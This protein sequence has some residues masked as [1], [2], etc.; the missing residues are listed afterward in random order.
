MKIEFVLI[1]T[2]DQ[3]NLKVNWYMKVITINSLF[4]MDLFLITK[5]KLL[6]WLGVG[7][8]NQQLLFTKT[9]N[10]ILTAQNKM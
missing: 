1:S 7:N 9:N 3:K 5:S 6:F 10:I 4:K 8:H 2:K